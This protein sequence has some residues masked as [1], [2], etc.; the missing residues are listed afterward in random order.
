MVRK[1]LC[2]AVVA[3]MASG[4]AG[5]AATK[6][7]PAPKPPK[8]SMEVVVVRSTEAGCEPLCMEW[9][10]AEGEITSASPGR[11]RTAL[12]LA[13]RKGIPVVVHSYGG[14]VEAAL[15]IG[16]MIRKNKSPVLVGGTIF[17]GCVPSAKTPCKPPKE[18]QG[19]YSASPT[20]YTGYCT[21][22]CGFILAGGTIRA[23]SNSYSRIGTHQI[24]SNPSYDSIRYRETYRIINGK[25]K[26]LSRKILSR[27]HVT[28]KPTT[29]LGKSYEKNLRK[30]FE[31]MGV[32]ASYYQLFAKTAP[33]DMHML[34][35]EELKETRI[36]TVDPPPQPMFRKTLCEGSVPAL[37]CVKR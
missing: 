32:S 8:P 6:K 12:K 1:I 33:T 37:N 17:T 36:V 34:T 23:L 13:G 3:F 15:E 18:A 2:L 21:S 14:S 11:F 35:P 27:K 10:S 19:R 7:K 28:L 22:A 16:R 24:V 5:V 25:K 26:I 30:Y 20:T 4:S 29:K 31:S 9:I